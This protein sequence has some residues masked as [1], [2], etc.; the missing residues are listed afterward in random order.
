MKGFKSTSDYKV[1]HRNGRNIQIMWKGTDKWV[2]TGC[3]SEAEFIIWIEQHTDKKDVT[4]AKYAKDFFMRTDAHSQR[5]D[6]E[7]RGR[8]KL[9]ETYE[10]QD[11]MTNQFIIPFFGN[12][13]INQ[14][15]TKMIDKWYLSLRTKNN[16]QPC[17]IYRNYALTT[18]ST[19]LDRAVYDEIIEVNPAKGVSRVVSR[20]T[21]KKPLTKEN[22]ATL[23]SNIAEDRIKVWGSPFHAGFFSVFYD[24]GFR[25]CEILALEWDNVDLIKRTVYTDCIVDTKQKKIE[26]RIKTVNTGKTYKVGM[27]SELTASILSSLPRT[28]KYVFYKKDNRL[29]TAVTTNYKFRQVVKKWC[30]RTDVSQYSL[31]HAFMTNLIGKVPRNVIMELMGHVKYESCYDD[32]DKD[33]VVSDMIKMIAPYS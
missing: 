18:L 31:R 27:I 16:K 7:V 11:S 5:A 28:D 21:K 8:I 20:T 10:S 24:T 33:R 1:T 32:R 22:L 30:G 9:E 23:F 17:S 12:M 2:S 4:L 13:K 26:H 3:S 29:E 25:P 15:T 19:I 6:D 14:I